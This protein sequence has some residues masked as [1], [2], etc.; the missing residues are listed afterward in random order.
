MSGDQR[1]SVARLAV[2]N[3]LTKSFDLRGYETYNDNP[4]L[5]TSIT[6]QEILNPSDVTKQTL[7]LQIKGTYN[8]TYAS[9]NGISQPTKVRLR[10]QIISQQ[11]GENASA[12]GA[13]IGVIPIQIHK[14]HD[15]YDGVN[16]YE[17]VRMDG[18]SYVDMPISFYYG[19]FV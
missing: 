15:K 19:D 13:I 16:A 3:L 17:I 10:S 8:K 9:N 6:D 12:L 7:N 14:I 5:S 2:P 4:V 18:N 11:N 1:Y